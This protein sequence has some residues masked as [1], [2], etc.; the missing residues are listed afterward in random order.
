[1]FTNGVGVKKG[2]YVCTTKLKFKPSTGEL[3]TT[4]V[5]GAVYNDIADLI[6]ID[7]DVE[8]EY[9]KAYCRDNNGKVTRCNKHGEHILGIAS[10][11]FGFC[12][13]KEEGKRKI[14]IAIGGWVLAFILNDNVYKTGTPL[15]ATK[16]GRLTKA[17][18]LIRR[19]ASY[20]IVAFYDRKESSEHWNEVVVNNR[21]WV[22]IL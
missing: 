2:E 18:W 5:Y 22:R 13:G 9:G 8:I 7:D 17:S 19:F 20:K 1:M 10:D 21:S 15:V 3:F 16:N 6:D 12:L 14:P 4:K 11:T